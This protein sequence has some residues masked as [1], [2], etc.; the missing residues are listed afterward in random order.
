M[1]ILKGIGYW[2]EESIVKPKHF[3]KFLQKFGICK[4]FETKIIHEYANPRRFTDGSLTENER[5][6]LCQYLSSGLTFSTWLGYARCRFRCGVVNEEMGC[7]DLSDGVW[8]W[9]EGLVHYVKEHNLR[10]PDEFVSHARVHNW[11][12]SDETIVDEESIVDFVFWD[13]WCSK[14]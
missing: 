4:G 1:T 8:V 7:R 11:L 14:N 12:V 6:L 10:L 3:K 2:R 5:L 9:P 13:E